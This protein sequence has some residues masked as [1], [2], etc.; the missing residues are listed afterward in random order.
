LNTTEKK[1]KHIFLE[2][3]RTQRWKKKIFK[4]KWININEDKAHK[5]ISSCI[6]IMK[7]KNVGKL[8]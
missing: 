6:V 7:L 2:C 4:N 1:E 3:T 8:L 5:K